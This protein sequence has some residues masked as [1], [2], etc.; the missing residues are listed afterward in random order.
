M[1]IILSLLL[2]LFVLSSSDL[3]ALGFPESKIDAAMRK[4]LARDSWRASLDQPFKTD[5][6]SDKSD[7]SFRPK[8]SGHKSLFKAGLYSAL[9]PGGGQLY[10]GNKKT[11]RYFLAA[12]LVTWVGYISFKTYG[13]WKEDD[14]IRYAAVHANAQVGDKS[15]EF[16]D[17]VGFYN[18]IYE[19]N[20]L[21]RV[22]DPDREY[23]PDTPENHWQWK[24]EAD[25][26][27]FRDLKNRS[28]EADRRAEFMIGIAVVD[29][30]ISIIDAVRGARRANN[31]LKTD[32]ASSDKPAY[33]ISVN[34]FNSRNQFKLTIYP[35]F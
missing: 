29:R 18:D 22:F 11:A 30:L 2:I 32:F 21:G 26:Y 33:K 9:I 14:Y 19:Y 16:V 5:E 3:F 1:R 25:R 35:G 10:V 13:N 6:D 27:N 23:L 24:S 8:R 12:E 17:M 34:P 31:E 15:E 7:N 4:E 20:R 28:R